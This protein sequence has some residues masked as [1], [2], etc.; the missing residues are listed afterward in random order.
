MFDNYHRQ[1]KSQIINKIKNT[2]FIKYS[3]LHKF[4]RHKLHCIIA[5]EYRARHLQLWILTEIF[6]DS[7]FAHK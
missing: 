7:Y 1:S 5:N 3:V 4:G 2:F 6:S